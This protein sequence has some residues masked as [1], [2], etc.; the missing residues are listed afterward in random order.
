MENPSKPEYDLLAAGE[1]LIDFISTDFADHFNDV[2][3]FTRFLG[4]SPANLC[5]NMSRLGKRTLL[6]ATLGQD[7]MGEWLRRQVAEPG[8]DCRLIRQVPQPTTLILVTRSR[9]VSNF[10]AYRSADNEIADHQFPS[11]VLR[12]VRLFHTTCFGLSRQPAQAA[13]IGAARRAV[14]QGCQLSKLEG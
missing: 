1:L 9:T 4:G 8:V 2:R 3:N 5:M 6:A 12:S 7:D 10:V 14:D 13:I 11:E